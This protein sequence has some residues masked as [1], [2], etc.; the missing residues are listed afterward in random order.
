MSNNREVC[1]CQTTKIP[2]FLCPS[3]G[4]VFCSIC[5]PD[6]SV[7]GTCSD[8]ICDGCTVTLTC[9]HKYCSLRCVSEEKKCTRDCYT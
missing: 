3:C 9:L 7:C 8:M 4:E 5:C 2:C 6:Y 1:V